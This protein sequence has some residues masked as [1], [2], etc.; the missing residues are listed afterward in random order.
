MHPYRT[1][2]Q[3]QCQGDITLTDLLRNH[4]LSTSRS[5]CRTRVI[6][7]QEQSVRLV[8]MVVKTEGLL[9]CMQLK[10]GLISSSS[11]GT[12]AARH[13]RACWMAIDHL[14]YSENS[15]GPMISRCFRWS[16]PHGMAQLD[17]VTNNRSVAPETEE[18]Q[19]SQMYKVGSLHPRSR[20][21]VIEHSISHIII[22]QSI[23]VVARVNADLF[24]LYSRNFR[25]VS[26][27]AHTCP[28]G[29]STHPWPSRR[30]WGCWKGNE[31]GRR[32]S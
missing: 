31:N 13:R 5:Q 12:I 16:N 15:R 9:N 14:V 8:N 7:R 23:H 3:P 4:R 25:K 26:R 18:Q 1:R 30:V 6:P 10:Q 21:P 20:K 29:K 27:S 19:S 28:R 11:P 24:G 2:A 22:G 17:S 32:S